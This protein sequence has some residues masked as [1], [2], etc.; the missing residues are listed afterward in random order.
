MSDVVFLLQGESGWDV[1]MVG[2]YDDTLHNDDGSWH[3][4]H[5]K[6]TFVR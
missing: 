2:R 3:F 5:R 4:H 1:K 6:A